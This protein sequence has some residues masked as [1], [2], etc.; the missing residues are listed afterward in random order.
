MYDLGTIKRKI[1]KDGV[2]NFI[3]ELSSENFSETI[4]K[5]LSNCNILVGGFPNLS[6]IYFLA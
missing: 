5:D 1:R 3:S 6:L 2:D 4:K